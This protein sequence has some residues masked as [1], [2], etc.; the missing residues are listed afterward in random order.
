MA[1]SE[2][3]MP[4]GFMAGVVNLLPVDM[5]HEHEGAR[6]PGSSLLGGGGKARDFLPGVE[7]VPHLLTVFGGGEEVTSRAEV[8]RDRPIRGQEALGVTRRLEPLHPPFSLARRLVGVLGAIVQIAMLPMLA[9]EVVPF[10]IDREE[11]FVQV[12]LVAGLG[13]STTKLAR[14][15]LTEL[16]IPLADRFIGHNDA[17]GEQELFHI[18]VAEAE[19]ERQPHRM[20]DDLSWE[21]V[22]L[23]AVGENWCVH[24]PSILHPTAAQQVDNTI[25][26]AG[27]SVPVGANL[28]KGMQPSSAVDKVT[29]DGYEL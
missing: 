17:T 2:K 6:L 29:D 19:A 12:P 21:S 10:A 24:Q 8:L 15:L 28:D 16:A 14:I 25:E 3:V 9:P 5:I 13:A 27:E 22:V 18:A 7:S 4:S 1:I 23:V 26:R 11:D 20:A